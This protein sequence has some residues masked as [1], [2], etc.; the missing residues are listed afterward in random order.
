MAYCG[1]HENI[2]ESVATIFDS[3]ASISKSAIVVLALL[4][5][6]SGFKFDKKIYVD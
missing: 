5:H 3:A 4:F 2:F 6:K 1:D